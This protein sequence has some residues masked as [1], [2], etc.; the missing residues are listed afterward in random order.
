MDSHALAFH[1]SLSRTTDGIQDGS[2]TRVV[3]DSTHVSV[4]LSGSV[5]VS[6]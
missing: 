3:V 2:A 4:Y 5:L 6:L 1:E